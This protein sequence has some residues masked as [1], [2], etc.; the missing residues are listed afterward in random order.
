[1]LLNRNSLI[2]TFLFS[3]L[4]LGCLNNQD[5]NQIPEDSVTDEIRMLNSD[6]ENVKLAYEQA[7]S[8]LNGMENYFES[9]TL[10]I[11]QIFVKTK[12]GHGD[13]VEHMWG[14]ILGMNDNSYSIR[15]DN[16]PIY[17][18]DVVYGDTLTIDKTEVEDF[19]VY[20]GEEL[21]LGDFMNW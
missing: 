6:D 4:F 10:G 17:V 19:L 11:Y 12:F 21:L 3:I 9:D 1:M 8:E 18:Q 7:Q 14:S 16:E 2:L 13:E 5:D 15:L 20:E